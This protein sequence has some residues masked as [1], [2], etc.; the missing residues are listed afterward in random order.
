MWMRSCAVCKALL[1][2]AIVG[3]YLLQMRVGVAEYRSGSR[4]TYRV[5]RG[6][7]KVCLRIDNLPAPPPIT[8]ERDSRHG[9]V[10]QTTIMLWLE[11]L[12][13]MFST[14]NH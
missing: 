4:K 1:K 10:I 5:S 2:T 11:E 12:P 13:P 3:L 7:E 8:R 9:Q 14:R 6:S